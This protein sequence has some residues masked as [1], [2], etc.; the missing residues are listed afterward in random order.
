MVQSP[1]FSLFSVVYQGGFYLLNLVDNCAGG[2]PL[3]IVCVGE[4]VIVT[5]IYGY[6]RFAE[7]VQM[8]VGKKPSLY[9]HITLRFI[10]PV[11]TMVSSSMTSIAQLLRMNDLLMIFS[12]T[13]CARLRHLPVQAIRVQRLPISS[14]LHSH[15][16]AHHHYHHRI[17]TSVWPHCLLQKWRLHGKLPYFCELA[18]NVN[19]C[20]IFIFLLKDSEESDRTRANMGTSKLMRS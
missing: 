17:P 19:T 4:L 15:H 11:L 16:V 10:S 18:H 9:F 14:A 5:W 20:S 12:P 2:Y 7:D 1:S 3:I 8:M 6:H 13:G